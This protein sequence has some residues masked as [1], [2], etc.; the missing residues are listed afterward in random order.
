MAVHI[1]NFY[2][3]ILFLICLL[4]DDAGKYGTAVQA[5]GNNIRQR[6]L[7]ACTVTSATDTHSQY[8]TIIAFGYMKA[9]DV[10]LD[11]HRCWVKNSRV[12]NLLN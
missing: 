4:W 10:T 2:G 12:S 5:T 3:Q 1:L 9:L 6:M 11:L 7:L 8:V